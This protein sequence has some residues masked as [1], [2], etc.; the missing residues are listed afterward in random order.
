MSVTNIESVDLKNIGIVKGRISNDILQEIRTEI[1]KLKTTNFKNAVPNNINLAGN[2]RKEFLLEDCKK[3]VENAAIEL[4]NV[5]KE[6]YDYFDFEFNISRSIDLSNENKNYELELAGLWVNLQEKYE[7]NPLHKHDG[8]FSFVIWVDIPYYNNI[9]HQVSPGNK[10]YANR[11][12]TFEF[13]Y[14]DVL[15]SIRG[16]CIQTD[17]TYEGDICLFPAKLHHLVQPFYSSNKTRVSVAGN[18]S[19]R[20]R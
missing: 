7:F 5:H 13:V 6:K 16:E 19:V 3:S 15:G 20:S 11:S 2:I 17:K 9:E 18:L 8:L 1:E 12:G 10:S 4:A 14:T